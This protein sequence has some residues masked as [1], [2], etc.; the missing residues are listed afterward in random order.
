MTGETDDPLADAP[1]SPLLDSEE[2]ELVD[3]FGHLAPA[4]RRA[5][6]QIARSMAGGAPPSET[7]HARGGEG[8]AA[9]GTLHDKKP[10]FKGEDQ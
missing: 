8:K 6:L 4:D 3:H 2:R 10:Q 7:V 5:L 9:R 1:Q